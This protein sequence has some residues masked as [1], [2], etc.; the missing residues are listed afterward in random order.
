[1]LKLPTQQE[2][3]VASSILLLQ[4]CQANLIVACQVNNLY[5]IE[6]NENIEKV[7]FAFARWQ[8]AILFLKMAKD[9]LEN[10]Q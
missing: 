10:I 6:E 7:E 3:A 5:E 1:M 4:H 2:E 9:N 8:N